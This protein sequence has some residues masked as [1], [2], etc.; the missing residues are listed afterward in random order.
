MDTSPMP[1]NK[2]VI[3]KNIYFYLVSFVALMMVV[4]SVADAVNIALKTYIFTKADNFNNYYASPIGCDPVQIK[5]ADPSIK[6]M[7]AEECAKINDEN[8]KRASEERVAQRQRD[9][10]PRY[11]F[12]GGRPALVYSPLAGGEKKR[13][14]KFLKARPNG[15]AFN[16]QK[17]V[18]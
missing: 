4:F 7:T 12:C 15:R 1:S 3:I 6:Q 17:M 10:V 2:I 13:S 5:G 11:F 18:K 9:V 14:L 16:F 8:L